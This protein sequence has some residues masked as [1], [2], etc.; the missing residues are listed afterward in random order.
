MSNYYARTV[1]PLLKPAGLLIM[2]SGLLHIFTFLVA[3]FNSAAMQFIIIGL[4]WSAIGFGLFRGQ[5]WLTC[6]AYIVMLFGFIAALTNFSG[7]DI[8]KWWLNLI[9]GIDLLA[10]FPLFGAIW[11][12][13]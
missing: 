7:L 6:I 3:G 11:S 12:K 13:K 4:I 9:A 8:P 10:L 2:L 5:K 1:S